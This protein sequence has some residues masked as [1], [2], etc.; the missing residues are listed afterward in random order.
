[1]AI[2]NRK[3]ST[4]TVKASELI[5]NPL[6]WRTHPSGQRD[7]LQAVLTNVGDVDYL[8]VV[9]TDDGLMLIDGHLRADIRGDDDVDV[10]VL[11]LT[12]DEQKLVL[13]TFDPLAA[14][15]SSDQAMLGGLLD[16]L[17]VSDLGVDALL[18][19]M[20]I[21]MLLGGDGLGE[22]ETK[23]KPHV[24]QDQTIAWVTA[25]FHITHV[26]DLERAL[27]MTG[28]LHR[29]EQLLEIVRYYLES[30]AKR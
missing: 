12:E 19:S 14:M 5:P 9:E 16:Q 25:H 27:A 4:R 30:H 22:A 18:A 2:R 11:D 10:V 20:E 7:A 21:D 6:N 8:K 1:M 26:G 3:V 17:D 13:A 24:P 23:A 15:A 28:K 29:G